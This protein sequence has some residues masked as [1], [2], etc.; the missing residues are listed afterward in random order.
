[1]NTQYYDLVSGEYLFIVGFFVAC[2]IMGMIFWR[3]DKSRGKDSSIYMATTPICTLLGLLV[4]GLGY[5]EDAQ[6]RPYFDRFQ[7][8]YEAY[9]DMDDFWINPRL[10]E[11]AS[12]GTINGKTPDKIN[13][14]SRNE[15]IVLLRKYFPSDNHNVTNLDELRR[16]KAHIR[17]CVSGDKK[18]DYLTSLSELPV[19]KSQMRWINNELRV[20][21]SESCKTT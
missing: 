18:I 19:S 17:A 13:N 9:E 15:S 12:S 10:E 8:F 6:S 1:M 3:I 16:L 11:L 4:F 5:Y 21:Y 2:V 7:A 20:L 14:A